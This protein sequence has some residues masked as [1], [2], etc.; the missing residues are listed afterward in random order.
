MT[1]RVPAPGSREA[2][3]P[4]AERP[5]SIPARATLDTLE[6]VRRFHT[7]PTPDANWPSV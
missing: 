1:L 6:G 3:V 4:D 5:N 2:L 7:E